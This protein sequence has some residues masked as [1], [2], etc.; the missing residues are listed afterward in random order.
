MTSLQ[1]KSALVAV[2][3]LALITAD[4]GAQESAQRPSA[5]GGAPLPGAVTANA[6][7]LAT[8]T[9]RFPRG[10]AETNTGSPLGYGADRGVAF[11]SVGYQAPIR[12]AAAG[13]PG[14]NVVIGAGIGD[15]ARLAGLEFSASAL[16]TAP[17]GSTNRVGLSLKVHRLLASNLGVAVGVQG[18]P[19]AGGAAGAR[20]SVFGVVSRTFEFAGNDFGM[21]RSL[22]WSVGLGS[23]SFQ[24]AADRNAGKHGVG[25]FS[26]FALRVTDL[27][28]ILVDWSGQ[29]L[30]IGVSFVPFRTLQL[31][32]T[33]M[34]TD[35]TGSSNRGLTPVAGVSAKTGPRFTLGVGYSFNQ[36]S[37]FGPPAAA[38]RSPLA[39]PPASAA[40]QQTVQQQISSAEAERRRQAANAETARATETS[41]ADRRRAAD[42]A[43]L[44]A[45]AALDAMRIALAR[46]VY[47]DFDKDEVREDQKAA[48]EAKVPILQANPA[49]RIRISGHTDERGSDE[50]NLA[51]SQRRA[52]SA[53]RYLVFRGIEADRIETVGLGEEV[54]VDTAH[55][56]A[57]WSK[58]RRAEFEVT[59]GG[60]DLRVPPRL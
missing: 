18:I 56:E 33:P 47:Y 29:D 10:I 37:L 19:L 2:A 24:L 34:I 60:S 12:Y 48:L 21:F 55:T 59:T 13:T 6:S 36:P 27:N 15:A 35:V 39:P 3:F 22:T 23:E 32:L 49:L 57:A 44:R 8:Q 50:Y 20:S 51:L 43:R 25:V 53:K 58:N 7:G 30:G 45:E 11:L 31:I 14:G 40:S 26:S 41:D 38:P 9:G 28:S 4:L 52:A 46:L 16:S 42:E 54:P 1:S 5:T 17:V